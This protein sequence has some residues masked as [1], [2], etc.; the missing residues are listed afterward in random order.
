[1]REIEKLRSENEEKDNIINEKN[2]E[3]NQ[4]K[5]FDNLHFL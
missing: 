3:I 1:M 4:I 2:K 5:I